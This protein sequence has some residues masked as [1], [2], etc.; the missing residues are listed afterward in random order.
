MDAETDTDAETLARSLMGLGGTKDSAALL[1][2][3]HFR[4]NGTAGKILEMMIRG[5]ASDP[6]PGLS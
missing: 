4:T 6:A 3:D 2:L 5:I 1:G